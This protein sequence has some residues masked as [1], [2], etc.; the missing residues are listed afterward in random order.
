MAVSD[1]M[2]LRM[3]YLIFVRLLGLLLLLSRTDR[4]RDVELLA[5]R[6]EVA[7]LRRQLGVRP[8]L[9]W[10]E[11]ALLAGLARQLPSRLRQHRLVTPGTLLT[12]HRRLVRW[13]W[14]QKPAATGRPPISEK[15][16][17]L[18]LRL[19]RENPTWGSTR[20]QGELHRLGYRVGAST[21]R[22]ILRSAGLGPAPRRGPNT[23]PTW[24]EF[25]RTQ[26]SGILAADFFHI[27]TTALTRLYAFTVMEVA[28]R[29]VHI[30]GVTTHPTAAWATQLAR[31][32]LADLGDRSSGFRYLLRDRDSRYTQAFDAVFT[33][34]NIEILKTAPQAPK[35]NAHAE[36]FIR[37]VRAECTDRVLIY[38]A[39]HARHVLTE[40]ARHHN[41][42]R[43]HRALQLHAPADDPKVIPFP[44]QRIHRHDVLGG[45]I[46]E[47]RDTA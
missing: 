15:F 35:M 45:L 12:W 3:L 40:Y 29:T 39:Q 17:A 24:A 19:A 20:I 22:R 10:P 33:S 26:A 1:P 6:H 43:P 4:A 30:L 16:T 47:Y 41:T 14:R 18:I 23:G 11:R 8:R 46:H 27:D 28:T 13:K 36:R 34:E 9:T 25:L 32:L 42:G 37:S 2:A 31:N 7:V 21:I 44:A 38:N 5:L